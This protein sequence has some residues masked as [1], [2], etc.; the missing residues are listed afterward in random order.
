MKEGLKF[1]T[2]VIIEVIKENGVVKE[3][4]EAP[5]SIEIATFGKISQLFTGDSNALV[6]LPDRFT[7]A[8]PEGQPVA[9]WTITPI[10]RSYEIFP[11]GDGT[12]ITF[13]AMSEPRATDITL[14]R[15]I[16]TGTGGNFTYAY[17]EFPDLVVETG[18]RIKVLWEWTIT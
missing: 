11:G 17:Q 12:K 6:G 2:N 1:K 5:N 10:T 3:R 13:Q 16:L 15:A 9:L 18:D 14:G 4:R 7:L 8:F